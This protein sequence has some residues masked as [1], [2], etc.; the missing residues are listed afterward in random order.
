MLDVLEP[1]SEEHGWPLR[2]QHVSFVEGRGNIIVE[3]PGTD[4][5]AGV[6]SFVGAHMV[7][8][9]GH[10]VLTCSGS[11]RSEFQGT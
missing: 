5:E 1:L 11:V 3:Y 2:I 7:R 8:G 10:V 9:E 6:V 4:P